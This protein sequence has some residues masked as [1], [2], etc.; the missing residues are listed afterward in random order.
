MTSL[1]SPFRGFSGIREI[2]ERMDGL[3][4]WWN[5]QARILG[6]DH[7]G[8]TLTI[9]RAEYDLIKRWPKA[10]KILNVD[11]NG[12]VIWYRGFKLRPDTGPGRYEKQDVPTTETI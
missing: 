9:K 12:E 6:A 2:T 11:Y 7:A 1:S 5:E 4:Q 3:V 10:G 8:K